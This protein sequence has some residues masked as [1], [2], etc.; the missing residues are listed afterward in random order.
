VCS[1]A[2]AADAK[3]QAL[4]SADFATVAVSAS[5]VLLVAGGVMFWLGGSSPADIPSAPV[6][7]GVGPAG[8]SVTGAF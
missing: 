7:L 1:N 6:A 8:V 5:A 3:H 4:R 2:A